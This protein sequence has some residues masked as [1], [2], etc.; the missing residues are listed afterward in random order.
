M[1]TKWIGIA[2]LQEEMGEL[3]VVLGKLHAYPDGEHPD[4][5]YSA[6]LLQRLVDEL[7]DVIAAAQWFVKM[8]V[9]D[10]GKKAIDWRIG[11]KQGRYEQWH[12]AGD[13]MTGVEVDDDS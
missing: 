2:K 9:D 13:H 11:Y 8:N 5:G 12:A 10:E 4:M 1:T 3:Q 6:P 7:A